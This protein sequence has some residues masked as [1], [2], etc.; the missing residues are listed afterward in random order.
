VTDG[1]RRDRDVQ[2]EDRPPADL[3]GEN[4]TKEGTERIAEAGDAEDEAAGERGTGGRDRREC[5]A[6]DGGPH[7]PAADPHPHPHRDQLLR[8]LRQPP[9]Q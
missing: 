9:E 7:Q 4:A 5:H 8:A 1:E 6:E 3:V 2:E